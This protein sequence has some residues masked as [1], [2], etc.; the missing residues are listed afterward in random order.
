[1]TSWS[2]RCKSLPAG[3]ALVSIKAYRYGLS[4]WLG[5]RCRH[6]PSCSAYAEEAIRLHGAARGG[7]LALKRLGRCQP[8]G[9][10]GYDPVPLPRSRP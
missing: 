4:P 9:T 1:M 5:A 3:L 7:W 10:Y 6:A 8:W 2:E